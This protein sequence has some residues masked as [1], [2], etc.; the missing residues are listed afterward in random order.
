MKRRRAVAAILLPAVAVHTHAAVTA[1]LGILAGYPPSAPGATALWAAFY[2]E[3]EARGWH[4]DRN[5]TVLARYSENHPEREPAYAAELVAAQPQVILALGSSAVEALRRATNTIPIVMTR[6]SHA[7]EAGFVRS[8]ARPGGNVTGVTNQA[9][10]M[11]G[12]LLELMRAVRP[13]LQQLGLMWSPHNLGSA[14]GL[15]DMQAAAGPLGVRVVSLPIER[16]EQIEPALAMALEQG[17]QALFAHPTS[18]IAIAWRQLARWALEHRVAT[19]G[20][21][22]WVRQGFLMSYWAVNTDLFRIAAGFADRILRGAK[23][24]TLPVQ[25]PTRFELLLNLRTAHAIGVTIP[26]TLRLRADEVI[27]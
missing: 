25:Q 3:L 24:A 18:V 21:A 10:D 13:E 14:I 27:E 12:K 15:R 1:R 7:V 6:V 5:L 9:S 23:P 16:S 22:H 4:V 2:S 8:M 26:N 17:V 19:L 20:Q 11:Q